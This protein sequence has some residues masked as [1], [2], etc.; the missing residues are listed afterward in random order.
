MKKWVLLVF[1]GMSI[2]VPARADV[3][4]VLRRGARALKDQNLDRAIKAF[5]RVLSDLDASRDQKVT[6]YSGRCAANYRISL[7]RRDRRLTR[8]AIG[9]CDKAIELKSNHQYSFRLRG[10]AHLTLGE[11]GKAL[12][13]LNVA[14]ALDPEDHLTLQNRGLANAKLG[15]TEAAIADFNIAIR[16]KPN[17]PWSFYN[18]GRLQAARGDHERAVEDFTTFLRHKTRYDPAYLHRGRNRMMLGRYQ[19]AVADFH[20]AL[21]L[22]PEEN[23][24]SHAYRGVSLYMLERYP[25]AERDFRAVMKHWPGNMENRMWLFLTLERLGKP[26]RKA[27]AGLKKDVDSKHWPGV[28]IAFLQGRTTVKQTL[29][30]IRGTDQ[31][32][33]RRDRESLLL[34]FLGEKALMNDQDPEA[35]Q[36]FARVADAPGDKP[37]IFHAVRHQIQRIDAR[38]R[39]QIQTAKATSE[40]VVPEATVTETPPVLVVKPE[41][42]PEKPPAVE[43]VAEPEV[44][45]AAQPA[46]DKAETPVRKTARI[47]QEAKPTAAAHTARA[48]GSPHQKGKYVFK[49]ASY[50][51]FGY[52]REALREVARLGYPVYSQV[53]TVRNHRYKRVWVG[54]FDTRE[55]A[56]SAWDRV[57][58][59]PGRTPSKIRRF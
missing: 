1:L 37:A 2:A 32:D 57:R 42:K 16:L 29:T 41:P 48:D 24:A 26:G 53:V 15:N 50:G 51:D 58:A 8:Q 23:P 47:I 39:K 44:A 11:P 4:D 10:T 7:D 9:D 30:T 17:H 21:R 3:D 40:P 55:A 27:F 59:L 56:Q 18:R 20:E 6:A 28:M 13:D 34:F 36:W 52:A 49:E 46:A 31:T 12:D 5:T 33:E 25:E 19:R 22:K 14:A 35:R 43:P 54:P 45:K 38:A